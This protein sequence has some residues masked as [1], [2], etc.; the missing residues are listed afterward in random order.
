MVPRRAIWL[1]AAGLVFAACESSPT[2]PGAEPDPTDDG[3]LAAQTLS[4][5]VQTLWEQLPALDDLEEPARS[6]LTDVLLFDEADA[7]RALALSAMTAG[8]M[9]LASS[10][11][12]AADEAVVQATLAG[13]G[14]GLAQSVV[15]DVE[16]VFESL[17][18]AV[19]GLSLSTETA[20]AMNEIRGLLSDAQTHLAAGRDAS[21][22][23]DGLAAADRARDLSPKQHA[24]I[25]IAK[26]KAWFGRATR[27]AGP[28]PPED[29]AEV[30]RNAGQHLK[31]AIRAFEAE[32]YRA[33]VRAARISIAHSRWVLRQLYD[34][35]TTDQLK[36]RAEALIQSAHGWLAR[37]VEAAGTE[38][39]E[40]ISKA[41]R[42]ADE[43]LELAVRAFEAEEYRVA[44]RRA[45]E[46][47]A[48]A[49]RVLRALGG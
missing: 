6:R 27:A 44:I 35:P 25:A 33:A 1:L 23:S 12:V 37:A 22:V 31:T 39:G 34:P 2:T 28:N 32:E 18:S 3:A 24:R 29:I 11:A 26:A 15:A 19:E 21:A 5:L 30:L 46:T 16:A 43:Q 36:A 9:S 4:D 8:D 13:A 41:L 49:R 38:P 17:A 45:A 40:D 42:I 20:T 7:M 10:Y 47:I 48:I 14:S